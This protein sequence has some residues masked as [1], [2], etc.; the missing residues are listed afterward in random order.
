MHGQ[1]IQ[2]LIPNADDSVPLTQY[3]V[4]LEY[5][6][7]F[8]LE[9]FQENYVLIQQYASDLGNVKTNNESLNATENALVNIAETLDTMKA[10]SM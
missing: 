4:S 1:S 3:A 2:T 5:E 7:L 10:K 6:D 9:Q 8:S